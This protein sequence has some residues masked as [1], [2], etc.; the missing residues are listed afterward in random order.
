MTNYL[1]ALSG[2]VKVGMAEPAVRVG[3]SRVYE[4]GVG[5]QTSRTSRTDRTFRTTGAARLKVA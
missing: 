4:G 2:F 5:S 1:P 3:E